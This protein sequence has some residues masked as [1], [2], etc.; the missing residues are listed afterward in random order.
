MNKFPENSNIIPNPIN[1]IPNFSYGEH[2]FIPKFPQMAQPMVE[3]VL[4]TRY[5]DLFH[6]DR[7]SEESMLVYEAGESQLIPA[8]E[9]V[10][11][12]YSGVKVFSLPSM[13][14]DGSRRHVELGVRGDPKQVAEAAEAL[15]KA[16]R[17]AGF[18]FSATK[19]TEPA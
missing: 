6:R 5:R 4:E 9:A 17:E 11:A 18:P 12:A 3:W 13:G 15:R 1:R 14:N 8:M 19:K 7:W 2:H 16:V 10:G